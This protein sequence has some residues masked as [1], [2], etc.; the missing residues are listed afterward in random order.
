[1]K[2]IIKI[3]NPPS[4]SYSVH[5]QQNKFTIN[6]NSQLET[7]SHLQLWVIIEICIHWIPRQSCNNHPGR[8]PNKY[9]NR[10]NKFEYEI[11]RRMDNNL[12]SGKILARGANPDLVSMENM[13]SHRY[14]AYAVL[15][16]FLFIAEYF[17]YSILQ[18]NN[19]CTLYCDNKEI[20]KKI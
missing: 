11:K 4:D 8:G 17:K 19:Q 1:M 5:V 12:I 14:A 15:S 2:T 20:V 13:H 16:A 7:R 6:V 10:W 18:L 9:C 3:T